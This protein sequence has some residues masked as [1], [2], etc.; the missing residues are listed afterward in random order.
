MGRKPIG[1]IVRAAKGAN[2]YVSLGEHIRDSVDAAEAVYEP[3]TKAVMRMRKLANQRNKHTTELDEDLEARMVSLMR[4][5]SFFINRLK[6]IL[7]E[8]EKHE[9]YLR[10]DHYYNGR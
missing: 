7:K 3:M 4:D 6:P 5:L 9:E 2:Q 8:G 10:H 1:L